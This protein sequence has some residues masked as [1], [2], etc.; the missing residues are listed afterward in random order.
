MQQNPPQSEPAGDQTGLADL[1][2]IA[3]LA[4]VRRAMVLERFLLARAAQ[5]RDI[6]TEQRP[7]AADLEG[8]EIWKNEALIAL[9]VA[10]VFDAVPTERF[11]GQRGFSRRA[12][13]QP[14]PRSATAAAIPS[15][16]ETNQTSRPSRLY[17][18]SCPSRETLLTGVLLDLRERIRIGTPAS[19]GTTPT[20]NA[21]RAKNYPENGNPGWRDSPRDAFRAVV[22]YLLGR[23]PPPRQVRLL[24]AAGRYACAICCNIMPIRDGC[25]QGPGRAAKKVVPNDPM[26]S[27]GRRRSRAASWP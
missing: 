20:T 18:S 22:G 21:I 17:L 25:R 11:A 26:Q 4:H 10:I 27:T 24:L 19:S 12:P 14:K 16:G 15:F 1:P 8:V 5:G 13:R 23:S 9:S 7:G 3:A 6:E 2:C